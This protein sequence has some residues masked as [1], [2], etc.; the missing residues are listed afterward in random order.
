M[1]TI[2][3]ISTVFLAVCI[4]A[5]SLIMPVNVNAVDKKYDEKQV[6]L[7]A[8]KIIDWKKSENGSGKDGYLINNKFLEAA[9]TTAGDWFPIGLSR[10]GVKDDYDTYLAIIKNNIKERYSTDEKLSRHKA[11]EWHRISLAVLA[12]GGDPTSIGNDQNGKPIDLI[13]DGTYNRGKAVSLGRQGINGWIW[14][15]IA[16]DSK[17]YEVPED[18]YNSRD[19]IITEILKQQ[20]DDGGFSL[21]HNSS[22]IDITAM[23]LQALSP[24][25]NS[26]KKYTYTKKSSKQEVTKKVREVVDESLKWLSENQSETGEFVSWGTENVESVNQ[27]TVA[28]CS[29]GIDPLKD[30]RFIKNGNTVLDVILR[31]QMKDGGFTHSFSYDSENPQ[32][33]PNESNSLAS[34]Q[35]LYTMAALWRYYNNMRSLYDFREEQNTAIKS[36]IQSLNN[37]ILG[38]TEKT[39]KLELEALLADYFS[40]PETERCYVKNYWRLSDNAVQLG[41][42]IGAIAEKTQVVEDTG[43]DNS[44]ELVYNFTNEDKQAVDSLP[45]ALTTEYYISVIKLLDK[46]QMS[47]EFPDKQLY[48]DKLTKAKDTI[49]NIAA[50]IDALNKDI[51]D[52][53]YPFEKISL[54]NK[55]DVDNIVKRYELLSEYDKTKISHWEDVVKTKTKIDN[56]LRGIIIGFVLCVIAAALIVTI[57][58]RIRKRKQKKQMEIEELAAQYE[59]EDN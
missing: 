31:Y 16:L 9:G 49:L 34:E 15:L 7:I 55:S 51:Q 43:D 20:L 53:L 5:I 57:I 17:R 14:G 8:N 3:T 12:A 29:L 50:E 32:A 22:D 1:K 44:N 54:K 58:I 25:Y 2:K 42:D 47:E 33:K 23:A 39:S 4:I 19:D 41:I 11:T 24:Y 18:A 6:L 40:L 56:L 52:K 13:A 45:K 46:L 28:L 36:R 37:K 26:E 35:T 10:L 38:I 59:D 21:N 27:V 48:F 30:E